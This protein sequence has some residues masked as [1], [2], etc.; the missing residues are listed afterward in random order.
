MTEPPRVGIVVSRDD[1]ASEHI[2]D[3]LLDMADWTER[4]EDVY[5][6]EGFELRVYDDLH[7]HLENVAN[8]FTNPDVLV[9]V[10]RHSGETGALLSAHFTGNFGE[11]AYGGTARRLAPACPNAQH[12]VI[13]A[14]ETNAPDEYDVTLEC[15]HHGPSD[16]GAPSM[17]VELGSGD[18]QWDD[19]A[20]ARAV[21]RAVLDLQDVEPRAGRTFVS[22]GGSHYAPRPTRIVHDT[23]WS[24]GHIAADWGLDD[25]GIPSQH[26]DVVEQAFT[27]SG[28][29][30][31]IVEGDQ[32]DLVETIDELGYQVV[33]ETWLRETA[34]VP[35]SLVDR[36][37]QD[38]STVDD[39]VRFGT[40]ARAAETIEREYVVIDLPDDLIADANGVDMDAITTAARST[41]VAYE[42]RENGNRI[43]GRAA[44]HSETQYESFLD[45]V[46]D[47]LEREY[48]RVERTEDAIVVHER[49]FDPERAAKLGVPEGPAF[50]AL[51]SGESVDVDERT[52]H[53]SDVTVERTE[54]YPR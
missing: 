53:P 29:Q 4:D 45:A 14:L 31:A 30:Y 11:A 20:G 42:T 8:D 1:R 44:F 33:S 19:P 21:A 48:E 26:P 10:S 50:G 13:D 15:T 34:G 40:D 54:R 12:A 7:L 52:V 27:R 51:A 49:A 5:E 37:E 2:G 23:D 28:A 36:L 6:R 3:A 24:C 38:L 39:G 25:L 16:P 43:V 18:E 32:P 46:C 47:V 17:F 41:S 35:L 22:F 9:F